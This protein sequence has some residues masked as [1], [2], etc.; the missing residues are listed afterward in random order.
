MPNWI[1]GQGQRWLNSWF[2][3]VALIGGVDQDLNFVQTDITLSGFQDDWVGWYVEILV[4]ITITMFI[5][6][7]SVLVGRLLMS[8]FVS[9]PDSGR[10]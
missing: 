5:L 6:T 2:N 8:S 9:T 10:P 7:I 4:C 1:H 3:K